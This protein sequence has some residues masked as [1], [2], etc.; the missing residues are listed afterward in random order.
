METVDFS[1]CVS[2]LTDKNY[3]WVLFVMDSTHSNKSSC[4][5]YNSF[6]YTGFTEGTF[7]EY[8]QWGRQSSAKRCTAETN[9]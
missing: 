2:A 9:H 4:I 6:D 1:V 7:S 5:T 8:V 3:V